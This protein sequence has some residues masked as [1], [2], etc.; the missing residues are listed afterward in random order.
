MR[1]FFEWMA[2]FDIKA[3]MEKKEM[4]K[5]KAGSRGRRRR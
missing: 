2:Y 3:K 1:E 5:A 4:N